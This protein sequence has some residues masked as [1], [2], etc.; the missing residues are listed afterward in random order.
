M[1]RDPGLGRDPLQGF[2]VDNGLALNAPD[3]PGDRLA[4]LGQ[5][6]GDL[7]VSGAHPLILHREVCPLGRA[8][9]SFCS[10][11]RNSRSSRYNLIE[12]EMLSL[13]GSPKLS[14]GG[15]RHQSLCGL[16]GCPA[17]R[18]Q[19]VL[20]VS[21][22]LVPPGGRNLRQALLCLCASHQR[23]HSLNRLSPVKCALEFTHK[24]RL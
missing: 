5:N 20:C 22:H 2:V 8:M 13:G 6:V 1:E 3:V 14:S 17:E 15:K 24:A 9:F 16:F 7:L 23:D 10:Y 21:T 11:S 12:P 4:V 18:D 19:A